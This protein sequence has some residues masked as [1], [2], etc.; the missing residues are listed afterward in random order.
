MEKSDM[1]HNIWNGNFREKE[2]TNAL[3]KDNI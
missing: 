3:K 1:I 2:K